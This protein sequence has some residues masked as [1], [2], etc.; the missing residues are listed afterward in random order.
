MT[1]LIELTKGYYASID[2]DLVDDIN[3]F[4]WHV[5]DGHPRHRYAARWIPLTQPKRKAE[6]MHHRV[7]GIKPEWLM[8]NNLVIDHIDRDGLNNQRENLRI[9]T[10]SL[11]AKNSEHWD[12]CT[13]IR[14]D[15]Y[16]G[17]FKVVRKDHTFIAWCETIEEAVEVRDANH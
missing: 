14:W 10:R 12:N 7:L 13:W 3:Q 4:R 8:N 5:L 1:T 15:G 16:R 11:N 6:R 2:D 9:A 17:R